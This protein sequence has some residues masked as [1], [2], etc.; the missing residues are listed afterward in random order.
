MEVNLTY[1]FKIFVL[2]N[3]FTLEWLDNNTQGIPKCG[4]INNKV[5]WEKRDREILDEFIN[6]IEQLLNYEGKPERVTIC[7]IGKKIGKLSI[8]EKHLDKLSLTKEYLEQHL[9]TVEKYQKRRIKWAINELIGKEEVVKEWKVLRIARLKNID[10][11]LKCC[12]SK[13]LN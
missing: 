1:F 10:E 4:I 5:D 3:E 12:L 7:R 8:L 11:N 9:E 6:V 2:T 13:L